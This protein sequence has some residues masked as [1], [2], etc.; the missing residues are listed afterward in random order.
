MR[1]G[2][3]DKRAMITTALTSSCHWKTL[4]P[5]CLQKKNS[6]NTSS[7]LLQNRTEKQIKRLKT[8]VNWLLND[9]WR[10]LVIGCFVWKIGV[11][12]HTVVRV[13]CIINGEIIFI[14]SFIPT[15]FS[16]TKCDKVFSW[17]CYLNLFISLPKNEDICWSSWPKSSS[18]K[19]YKSSISNF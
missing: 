1:H 8:T 18:R 4:A 3:A 16:P 10:Y 12:Q 17:V 9:I 15:R 2:F 11:S 6:F 7:E 14:A 5:F 13:Y 19:A